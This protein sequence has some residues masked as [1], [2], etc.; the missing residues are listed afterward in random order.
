MLEFPKKYVGRRMVFK[1]QNTRCFVYISFSK[2]RR[3]M[4]CWAGV[5]LSISKFPWFL[6]IIGCSSSFSSF[7]YV[8]VQDGG[9]HSPPRLSIMLNWKHFNEAVHNLIAH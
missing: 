1:C 5:F 8:L 7:F 4:C 6:H 9:L 2:K 3:V